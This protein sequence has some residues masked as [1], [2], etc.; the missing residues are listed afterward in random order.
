MVYKLTYN[1]AQPG[2][3]RS[4]E[5]SKQMKMPHLLYLPT[6]NDKKEKEHAMGPGRYN[7][8]DFIEINN[9]KPTSKCNLMDTKN[10]RYKDIPNL[11]PGPGTYDI[12]SEKVRVSYKSVSK[13]LVLKIFLI[14]EN[15]KKLPF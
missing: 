7:T 13:L 12:Y 6:W 1:R 10:T 9:E 15:F 5:L 3:K 11:T 2:W 8:K 14:W 4:Y